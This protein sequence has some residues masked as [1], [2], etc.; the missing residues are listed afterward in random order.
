MPRLVP[1]GVLA[2]LLLALPAA[3]AGAATKWLCKPG[4]PTDACS[5]G[6]ATTE[7]TPTGERLGVERPRPGA[8]EIDCFYVYPT[9][10]DQTTPIAN[11][12]IDPEIR[13][14]ALYQAARYKQ[15]CRVFAPVYRQ[16]TIAGIQPGVSAGGPRR[17]VVNAS[18]YAD[19]RAA[20]NEYLRRHNKG[21]GVVLVGHSQGTFVLRELIKREI[22]DRRAVRRR[23]V[24]ALLLGGNA[25]DR[26][27]ENLPPCRSDR[28]LGCVV[29]FSVYDE[30]PPGGALFGRT[31]T[32][33]AHV[34]CTNPARLRGGAATVD[35]IYPSR[36]FAPG[37]LISI[38]IQLLG[39]TQPTAPTPWITV[40][41][42]YRAE[43]TR[44][45]GATFLK[46][47]PLG[48]AP[49]FRPSPTPEWGLHLVDGN[50]ALGDLVA[51]VRRQAAA[52]SR[53]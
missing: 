40:K 5:P 25:T 37:T 20:W 2:A 28:Q 43:C 21:R 32:A 33:G 36:P 51:L 10:S 46:L 9:V 18:G 48:D 27:F 24:S 41:D 30:T 45:A 6:L 53:R 8:R 4:L 22:D 29:A 52:V 47:T 17:S 44:A 23:I 35:T 13:S 14:I 34:L 7:F 19:V 16:R 50:I 1:L 38:G 39:V 15:E 49:D 26:E 12:R 42:A 3:T 11:K 31:A